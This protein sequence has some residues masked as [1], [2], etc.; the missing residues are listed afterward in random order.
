MPSTFH[1]H[2]AQSTSVSDYV[3]KLSCPKRCTVLWHEAHVKVR[4]RKTRQLRKS[5]GSWYFGK[6]HAVVARS[7][8][9]SQNAQNTTRSEPLLEVDM[10]EK[11]APLQ[12]QAHVKVKMQKTLQFWTMFGGWAVEKMHT[13]VARSTCQRQNAQNTALTKNLWKL[14]CRKSARGLWRETHFQVKFFQ[15]TVQYRNT[16]GS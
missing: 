9:P 7:T 12:R 16:F 6:V 4:M 11:C 3:W 8:C 5:F 1:G 10:L 14:I 15:K 2:I 13:V